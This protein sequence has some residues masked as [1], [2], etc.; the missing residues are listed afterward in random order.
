MTTTRQLGLLL[1][2]FFLMSVVPPLGAQTESTEAPPPKVQVIFD[3]KSLDGWIKTKFGGEG[4]VRIEEG[5]LVLGMGNP[6]TGITWGDPQQLPFRMDYEI[7]LEARR[8]E[9]SDFFCGLTFPHG[10][11]YASLIVGGWGGSLVGISCLDRADASENETTRI[12]K[13]EKGTWYKIRLR[14]RKERIQAWI[15]D[16]MVTD[17][18]IRGRQLTT[19]SEVRLCQPLGISSFQTKAEIRHVTI[20]AVPAAVAPSEPEKP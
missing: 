20:K 17:C 6:L 7:E 16:K 10:E 3:G 15:D 5:S 1:S 8:V 18:L 14:V 9:G 4:D 12:R 19:R 2:L 11:E 13:F